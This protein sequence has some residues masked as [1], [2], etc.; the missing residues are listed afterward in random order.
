[1]VKHW[2]HFPPRLGTSSKMLTLTTINIFW[3]VLANAIGKEKNK[4]IQTERS[5]TIPIYRW[6]NYLHRKFQGITKPTSEF[7]NKIYIIYSILG[8]SLWLGGK[9]TRLPMQETWVWSLVWE[10]PISHRVIK[11]VHN[12]WSLCALGPMLCNN[13]SHWKKKPTHRN[14][15]KVHAATKTQHN[16]K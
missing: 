3:E 9:K 13:R 6:H 5:K 12:Y 1:M 4:H 8:L 16:Q 15:R 11:L 7:R 10:D 14:Q 2:K